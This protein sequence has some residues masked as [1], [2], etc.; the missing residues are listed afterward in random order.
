[1]P[2]VYATLQRD[3]YEKRVAW[4][5]RQ[6]LK[7]LKYDV[8]LDTSEPYT[9]Y[10]YLN[11]SERLQAV[12][13]GFRPSS[14]VPFKDLEGYRR[15]VFSLQP[16]LR[17]RDAA[18]GVI[19]DALEYCNVDTAGIHDKVTAERVFD[20]IFKNIDRAS[21]VYVQGRYELST[22][23]MLTVLNSTDTLRKVMRLLQN[24]ENA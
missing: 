21:Y 7:L 24:L 11:G 1:M 20:D 3:F 14:L 22:K 9:G 17:R 18:N 5:E 23:F 19:L 15:F 6:V 16:L 10:F 2:D 8:T 12:T 4:R 13:A